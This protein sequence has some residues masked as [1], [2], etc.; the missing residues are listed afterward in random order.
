MHAIEEP[1]VPR[2][3]RG[4]V[5]TNPLGISP[6]FFR[7]ILVSLEL[8]NDRPGIIGVTSAIG[9]EGRTTVAL[10]LATTMAG[11]FDRPVL[12]A[13]ADLERP[14]LARWLA[15]PPSHGLSDV[16]RGGDYLEDII[17]PVGANLMVAPAGSVETDSAALVR[18]VDALTFDRSDQLAAV[19]LDL[20][21]VLNNS[22]TARAA[23]MADAVILVVRAGITPAELVREAI[24]R[25]GDNVPV[26]VVLN[27]VPQRGGGVFKRLFSRR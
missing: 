6:E 1:F 18:R 11:D 19:V 12:L 21:P 7:Q 15:L 23:G 20:P 26:G 27:A 25:L 16:L 17:S 22:Y 13:E 8:P 24:R 10:G 3:I 9:G 5:P 4:D 14:S 2:V